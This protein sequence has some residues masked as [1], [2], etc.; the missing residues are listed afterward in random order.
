[1]TGQ[2]RG[3]GLLAALARMNRTTVFLVALGVAALGLFLP[4]GAGALLIY[5]LVGALAA[6]LSLTWSVT[7]SPLRVARLVILAGLT[8]AATLKI[9]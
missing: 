4:G 5:L 3:N 9:A 6:L 1:M 7:P 8:V 2:P